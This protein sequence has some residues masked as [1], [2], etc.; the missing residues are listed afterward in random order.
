MK[1]IF[2]LAIKIAALTLYF[3][4]CNAQQQP[5]SKPIS[6]KQQA[7]VI[8]ALVQKM[9]D[10]YIFP[11]V[12]MNAGKQLTALQKKGKYA[13]ITDSR[14]FAK[15]LTDDLREIVKDKH[16]G[17]RFRPPLYTNAP[18]A[19]E[20]KKQEEAFMKH[21]RRMNLGFAKADLLE[22]NV[23]Y[24]KVDGFGPVDKVGETCSG[25]MMFLSN[26]DALI[27]DLRDNHGGE[28]DMVRYL[29]SYFFGDEP[30]HLNDLYFRNG[31]QT[32]EFWTIPVPGK[33]YLDKP[34]YVLTSSHTF[35]GGEELAYDL[36]TQKRATLIGET[37][38][39]GANPGDEVELPEGFTAF[40]PGGRAINP[41]TKTNWEGTGVKPDI[42]VPAGNALK[43]AH[44]LALKELSIASGDDE[45]KN[46]YSRNIEVVQKK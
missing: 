34:V 33:K 38:G 41:I 37:T 29:A 30:V 22:G 2:L 19:E 23:G 14:E 45:A 5:P 1:Q 40:I 8:K 25:A 18:K 24:L 13:A 20:A 4:T 16:L 6:K 9:N 12:A 35:S 7:V 17:V 43:E 46:Y 27:I 3:T 42:A 28:P 21:M 15:A 31:N 44:L 10:G 39:G 36:Q 32:T 26:T 11:E